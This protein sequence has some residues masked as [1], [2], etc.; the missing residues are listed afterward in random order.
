MSEATV[1]GIDP[2][3]D[4]IIQVRGLRK[5][6]EVA[7]Q[8]FAWGRKSL[9]KAV[10]DVSFDL[11]PGETLGIVGESGCGKTVTSKSIMRLLPERTTIID[12]RSQIM[13]EGTNL[14]SDPDYAQIK[15]ELKAR[16]LDGWNPDGLF[17]DGG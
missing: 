14:A 8:G 17:D 11:Y 7:P 4:A 5:W 16:A 1:P 10:D 12:P 15:A 9:L 2:A 3:A 13:F 6:Y